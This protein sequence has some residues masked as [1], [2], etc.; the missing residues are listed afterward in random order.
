VT[1]GRGNIFQ[2]ELRRCTQVHE[3]Y[4]HFP[5]GTIVRWK[6]IEDGAKVAA[7][8]FVAV[9]GSRYHF[10]S[11]FLGARLQASPHTADVHY[12]WN[13]GGVAYSY[14][15]RREPGCSG[16]SR[17]GVSG[18]GNLFV[19]TVRDCRVLHVGYSYFPKRVPVLWVV[20]QYPHRVGGIFVAEPGNQYHFLNRALGTTLRP[21][22][23]TAIAFYWQIGVTHYHYLI[24][25]S[26]GC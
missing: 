10:I 14:F 7:G 25:R 9:G 16:T 24:S 23:K 2:V 20:G 21:S 15:V 17:I 22:S 11:Q 4:N 19:V 8:A 1:G 5:A 26:T 6:V 3:G 18:L 12:F 13:I